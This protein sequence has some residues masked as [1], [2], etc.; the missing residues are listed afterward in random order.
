METLTKLTDEFLK[1]HFNEEEL[2]SLKIEELKNK[3]AFFDKEFLNEINNLS[4][5]D[6]TLTFF[7]SVAK[8]IYDEV[9]SEFN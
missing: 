2:G 7:Q 9:Y 3:R 6:Q 8:D 5:K 4:S 1:S